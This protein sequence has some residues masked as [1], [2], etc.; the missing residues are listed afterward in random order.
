MSI[1]TGWMKGVCLAAVLRT[2]QMQRRMLA[3][4]L[5]LNIG[6]KMNNNSLLSTHP[7]N[8]CYS[9]TFKG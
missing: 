6:S 1:S 8:L 2:I 5:Q 7:I 3:S 4:G 9:S